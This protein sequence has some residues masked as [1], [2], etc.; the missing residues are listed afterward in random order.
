MVAGNTGL[1]NV[2]GNRTPAKQNQQGADSRRL[3][4]N[5]GAGSFFSWETNMNRKSLVRN[6]CLLAITLSVLLPVA[7]TAEPIGGML[8]LTEMGES[9]LAMSG[10]SID[11]E[12][13]KIPSKEMVALPVYP[14]SYYTATFGG[15]GMLPGVIMASSDPLEK[16]KAWYVEQ[17]GL[18]WNEMFGLFHTGDEY[19]MMVT[20]SVF[21]QDISANPSESTGGLAGFDM[22]GM[23]TQI[24]ISYEPRN[25]E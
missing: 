1:E 19:K 20:E 11:D 8:P 24:T 13:A 18:T 12:A 21:L 3:L 15:E 25:T 2:V 16:V 14:G 22:S 23:K 7:A 4:I 9:M 6:V 5:S 17:E 10:G